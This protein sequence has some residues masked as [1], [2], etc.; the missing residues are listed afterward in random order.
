MQ[1]IAPQNT[2]F[3]ILLEHVEEIHHPAYI[4]PLICRV[5][6][7]F[8]VSARWVLSGAIPVDPL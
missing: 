4:L 8:L 1:Y 5:Y 2:A 7:I 3:A 6:G